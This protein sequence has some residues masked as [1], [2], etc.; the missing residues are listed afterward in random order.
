MNFYIFENTK[1]TNFYPI[2]ATRSAVDI[3]VGTD[4]FLDRI[5]KLVSSEDK[6]L[7]FVREKIAELTRECHPEIEVNPQEVTKGIWLAGNVF[8]TSDLLKKLKR[9]SE[10]EWVNENRTVAYNLS[11]S[12]GKSWLK[13]GGPIH[14]KFSG[15]IESGNLFC[16]SACYL[17]DIIDRIPKTLDEEIGGYEPNFKI[18]SDPQTVRIIGRNKIH[19]NDTAQI[20]PF[21]VMNAE[22]GPI[23][24]RDNVHIHSFAY[25]EGP[26][27]IGNET[28]IKPH[29][30]I[31]TSIIGPVCKMGGEIEKCIFQGLSNKVHDG[32]LGNTFLGEW[33]NLGAGTTNSNLKN[34]Y[35]S[36][37]V[38][39]EQ[40]EID[41]GRCFI[42]SFI[43]DHVKTGIGTQLN[44][45]TVIGPCSNII[46]NSISPKYFEPFS[47]FVNGEVSSYRFED[48]IETAK[49]VMN[50]RS[51]KLSSK[52]FSF[53]QLLSQ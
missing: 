6:I 20:E 4:T 26:L 13:Q 12:A 38:K 52:E 41:T 21:V 24:I 15:K 16:D 32:H 34:T 28:V 9:S 53:Y 51:K 29:S 39:L 7:L 37:K 30:H 43:G 2:S 5:K 23:I 48:F 47:W 1:D 40:E 22:K 8:W 14:N 11:E 50:R 44:T 10:F 19:V 36:V 45:G 31:S 3:R 49:R 42:G 27:T 18:T 33:V 35:S 17:W 46:S 25:L